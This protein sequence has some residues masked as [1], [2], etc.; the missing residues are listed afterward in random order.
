[1]HRVYRHNSICCVGVWRVP[2][3]ALA[4]PQLRGVACIVFYVSW[5]SRTITADTPRILHNRR[6]MSIHTY[7]ST[8][9]IYLNIVWASNHWTHHYTRYALTRI[10]L[11]AYIVCRAAGFF[12]IKYLALTIKKYIRNS[13][14]SFLA[15]LGTLEYICMMYYSHQRHLFLSQIRIILAT[16]S[17]H[18]YCTIV[19]LTSGHI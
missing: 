1:M 5:A 2:H 10:N 3:S 11:F 17:F 6:E 16:Y 4:W 12:C 7:M 9:H 8:L 14:L 19:K 13:S 15:L 18:F